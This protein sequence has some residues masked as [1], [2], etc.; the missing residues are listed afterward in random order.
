MKDN[1]WKNRSD[2]VYS[3]NP[4]F[5]YNDGKGE[6][7]E[8]LPVGK[9]TLRITIDKRNRGGK[10]VTLV[11]GFIGAESDLQALGKM[12][13]VKCGVGGSVKDGEILIQ[14]ERKEQ[15][16]ALLTTAGYKVKG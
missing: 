11:T 7:A 5:N 2:V 3:T 4:D 8:T 9:Q 14:G 12:L 10:V 1:N 15:I 6:E 16:K 13:K